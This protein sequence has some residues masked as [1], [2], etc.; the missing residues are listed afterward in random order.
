MLV[1]SYA[2]NERMNQLVLEH[3][4]PAAWRATLPGSK[5][6]TIAAIVSH[7]HNVRLKWLRLS[8][9]HVKR[10]M[11]LDRFRCTQKEAQLALAQSGARC[12]EMIAEAEIFHRD[13]WAR[14]WPA[15]DAMVAYML[16]HDAHHRGQI[17]LLAH[18]LGYPLP[19]PASQGMWVW[20]R[21]FKQSA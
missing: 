9:P 13:G 10:P 12:C 5:T 15:D 1:E 3:L 7:V 8:V 4:D 20:E 2:V 11:R 16:T 14:P 6:R 17:C 19:P 18:Q 21:L